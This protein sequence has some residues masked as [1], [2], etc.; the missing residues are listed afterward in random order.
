MSR[1]AF[2]VIY[3]E[4][5]ERSVAFYVE[6]LGYEERFRMPEEGEAGYVGMSRGDAELAV[7]A[8]AWPQDQFGLE[9]GSGPRFELFAYVD[10]VDGRCTVLREGGVTVLKEPENLPWGERVA[11]VTDPDGNPVALAAAAG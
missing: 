11:W 2:P 7:V 3:S 9:M 8:A 10:D 5:V 1:R 4:D 6:Q